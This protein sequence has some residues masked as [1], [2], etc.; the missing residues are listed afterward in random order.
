MPWECIGRHAQPCLVL[1]GWDSR[2]RWI[3]VDMC[4]RRRRVRGEWV[5]LSYCGCNGFDGKCLSKRFNY[6][7]MILYTGACR[8]EHTSAMPQVSHGRTRSSRVGAFLFVIVLA[9]RIHEA[10]IK[11]YPLGAVRE[12]ERASSKSSSPSSPSILHS[13]IRSKRIG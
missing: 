3:R 11:A 4:P 7:M 12:A 10:C 13:W 1:R 2:P 9:N 6:R 8:D 5:A